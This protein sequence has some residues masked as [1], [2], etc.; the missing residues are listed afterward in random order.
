[1]K[2]RVKIVA[3]NRLEV[4]DD[5]LPISALGKEADIELFVDDDKKVQQIMKVQ[6]LEENIVYSLLDSVGSVHPDSSLHTK[7]KELING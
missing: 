2:Y 5:G 4:I 1:M 7:L 6:S 3:Q